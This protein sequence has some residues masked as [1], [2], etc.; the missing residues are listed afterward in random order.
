[1]VKTMDEIGKIVTSLSSHYSPLIEE[2]SLV[3]S[4]KGKNSKFKTFTFYKLKNVFLLK[5]FSW[6]ITSQKDQRRMLLYKHINRLVYEFIG[7]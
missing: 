2:V 5:A 6:K 1:M 4:Q 3:V 7:L